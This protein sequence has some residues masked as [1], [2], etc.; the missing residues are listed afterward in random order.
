MES[1]KPLECLVVLF[2]KI[3]ISVPLFYNFPKAY[4]IVSEHQL[5]RG[6][7]A[8]NVAQ[9][10][11]AMEEMVATM[12]AEF[13]REIGMLKEEF[14]NMHQR[15]EQFIK[16]QEDTARVGVLFSGETG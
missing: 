6:M 9:Q 14:Q 10:M 11:D 4:Q 16:L 1:S 3:N 8:K 5:T 13:Q 15:L 7:A 12:Q 2:H